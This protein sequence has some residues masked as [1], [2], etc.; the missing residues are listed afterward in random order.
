MITESK[1]NNL[2]V[3]IQTAPRETLVSRTVCYE[4]MEPGGDPDERWKDLSEAD[5][6]VLRAAVRIGLVTET[7]RSWKPEFPEEY[8]P[9]GGDYVVTLTGVGTERLIRINEPKWRR[10]L[11]QIVSNIPTIAVSVLTAVAVSWA[12]YTWGAP[13]RSASEL[14]DPVPTETNK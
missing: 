2:L 14:N 13:T 1:L 7:Y 12:V 10:S 6:A 8:V 9:D 5:G 4:G 3:H 11:R